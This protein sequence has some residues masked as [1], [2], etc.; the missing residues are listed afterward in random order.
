M[1]NLIQLKG[2]F[3]QSSGNPGGGGRSLPAGASV[4][5]EHIE[6]LLVD[7]RR[8]YTFWSSN[9][10]IKGALVCVYYKSVVAKS[11]RIHGMLAAGSQEPNDSIRGSKFYGEDPIQHVFTHYVKLS[12][13]E[14]TI[15]NLS[16]VLEIV[17]NKY[18]GEITSANVA[19]INKKKTAFHSGKIAKTSFV[20]YVVDSFYVQRFDIATSD[21]DESINSIITLYKTDVPTYDLL[22][23]VGI[24]VINAKMIDDTTILLSPD[25]ITLLKSK[26][27]YLIAMAVRDLREIAPEDIT[28]CDTGIVQIPDPGQ[29]P[30]IGVIDTPFD[31][32]VYFSKWVQYF[33]MIDEDI[34]II[35]EYSRDFSARIKDSVLDALTYYINILP[36]DSETKTEL[37]RL[38]IL[39]IQNGTN[40]ALEYMNKQNALKTR[41]ILYSNEWKTFCAVGNASALF[42]KSLETRGRIDSRGW[43][44]TFADA[45]GSLIC[46]GCGVWPGIVVSAI[47]SLNANYGEPN[48]DDCMD[49][50]CD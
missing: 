30:I 1:N 29:E 47:F 16:V 36:F 10:L 24:D 49:T 38:S 40:M 26:A 50:N 4:K 28:P 34:E 2:Q 42:W 35:A 39:D 19:S 22:R 8:V 43:F 46:A 6:Q 44:G 20:N 15:N 7:L 9:T 12:T 33:N 17:K 32:R 13:I 25:E 27:P 14:A 3:E 41:S 45:A 11:N 48:F 21:V 31:T 5:A 18:A 23:T 37:L